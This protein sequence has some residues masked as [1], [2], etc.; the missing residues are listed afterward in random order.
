[1]GSTKGSQRSFVA[2]CTAAIIGCLLIAHAHGQVLTVQPTT[3]GLAECGALSGF[4]D[5]SIQAPGGW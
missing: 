5:T 3:D 2:S 4:I 1:M